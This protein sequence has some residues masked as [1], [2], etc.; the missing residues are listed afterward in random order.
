M[1]VYE[2]TPDGFDGGTDERDSEIIW[3]A[4]RQPPTVLGYNVVEITIPTNSP[5]I[6]Y[7][8]GR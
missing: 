3:V 6:D 8:E 5:G 4:Y 2:L 7:I 1:E